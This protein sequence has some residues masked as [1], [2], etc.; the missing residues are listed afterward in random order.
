MRWGLRDSIGGSTGQAKVS[1]LSN[2]SHLTPVD[3]V[4]VATRATQ[5]E[6]WV[7]GALGAIGN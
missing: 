3:I 5:S 4:I 7:T 6:A 1:C 2:S